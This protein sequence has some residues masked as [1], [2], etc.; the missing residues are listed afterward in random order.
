MPEAVPA[1]GRV[2]NLIVYGHVNT[3]SR[4]RSVLTIIGSGRFGSDPFSLQLV[5]VYGICSIFSIS[6]LGNPF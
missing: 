6:S 5:P 1:S 4:S 3:V 2:R